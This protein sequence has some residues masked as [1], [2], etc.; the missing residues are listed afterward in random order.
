[1]K[2]DEKS[3]FEYIDAHQQDFIDLLARLCRQPS[4]A[5]THTGVDEMAEIAAEELRKRGLEVTMCPTHGNTCIIGSMPGESEKIFGFYDHYDVQPVEPLEEWKSDPWTLTVRDGKMYARGV[6]DNKGGLAASLAA[7]DAWLA[8]YGKLPCG[9][10]F[11]IEGEEEIGS[12]NLE[13]FCNTYRSQMTCDGIIFEGG[14]RDSTG[15][16]SLTFG[17]KGLLY[18]ELSAKNAAIDAHSSLAAIVENPAWRLVQALNTLKD[19]ETGKILID[20]FYDGII[21]LK[22]ADIDIL[23]KDGF[24]EEETRSYLGIN[25]FL[26]GMTGRELLK[27]YHYEPTCNIC[28][29]LSGYTGPGPKTVLPAGASCKIDFRLVPGQDPDRIL[30]LLQ[31]H[32]QAHGFSDVKA[33][34]IS[35]EPPYRSDPSSDFCQAVMRCAERFSGQVPAVDFQNAG[36]CPLACFCAEGNIPAAMAGCGTMNNNIHAPNEFYVIDDFLADIKF[37]CAMMHEL[38]GNL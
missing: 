16:L 21:P 22:Q 7:V 35:A 5:G 32:L 2:F 26:H 14:E 13:E 15:R 4:L 34:K 3:V 19:P 12:P 6:S 20:G 29:I 10:R 36:T 11:L 38:A 18:V 24:G 37:R 28:G 27:N 31:S 23:D 1:M 8:V 9:V 25:S 33:E 17:V 30:A